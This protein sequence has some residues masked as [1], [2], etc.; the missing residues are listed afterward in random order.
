MEE[1]VRLA[2]SDLPVGHDLELNQR[3]GA[4]AGSVMYPML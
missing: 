1:G 2:K 3:Y 4:K